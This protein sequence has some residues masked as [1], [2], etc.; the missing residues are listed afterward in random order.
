MA[1]LFDCWLV[2][3]RTGELDSQRTCGIEMKVALREGD[4]DAGFGE[5]T[6]YHEAK[7]ARKGAA[8]D[9]IGIQPEQQGEDKRIATKFFK[10]NFR[11]G[12]VF[13]QT[14]LISDGEE[15]SGDLTCG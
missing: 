9:L 12:I 14:V 2:F 7:I 4:D 15:E 1:I 6:V 13:Y 11:W 5:R 10:T 8:T 3:R